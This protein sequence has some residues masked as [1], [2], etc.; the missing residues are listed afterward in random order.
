[1]FENE[2]HGAERVVVLN[3]GDGIEFDTLNDTFARW[4]DRGDHDGGKY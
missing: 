3:D 2:I 1:M 4:V